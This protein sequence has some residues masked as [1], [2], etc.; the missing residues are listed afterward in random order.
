MLLVISYPPYAVL[1]LL[2]G[3][4]FLTLLAIP[5]L[6]SSSL[7]VFFGADLRDDDPY[8]DTCYQ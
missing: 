6:H 4:V 1:R 3:Y 2:V 5:F 8:Q 7:G